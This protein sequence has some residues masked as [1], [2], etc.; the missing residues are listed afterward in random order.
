MTCINDLQSELELDLVDIWRI[1]H[2][3][4]K[5]FTWSQQSPNIFCR[6][7][8]WLI[9]NNL[10]DLVSNTEIIPTIKTDHSA[11]YLEFENIDKNVKAAGF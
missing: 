10:Y 1:K 5:S 9:S 8:F 2:P 6:L 4:T 3:N 7:E 11:I